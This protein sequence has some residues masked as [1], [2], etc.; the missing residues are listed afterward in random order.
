MSSYSMDGYTVE[1]L[2]AEV[3]KILADEEHKQQRGRW[4]SLGWSALQG[5]YPAANLLFCEESVRETYHAAT[6]DG[7]ASV[8]QAA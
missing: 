4:I 7:I 5:M 2:Y 8:I 6:P 1:D 3:D